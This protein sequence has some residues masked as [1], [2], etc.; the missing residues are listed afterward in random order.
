MARVYVYA[1]I[2]QDSQD[3]RP[4][5]NERNGVHAIVHKIRISSARWNTVAR[6]DLSLSRKLCRSMRD[7][8]NLSMYRYISAY[9]AAL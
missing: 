2:D 7:G 4:R 1:L 5:R 6:R 9:R 3:F 8:I